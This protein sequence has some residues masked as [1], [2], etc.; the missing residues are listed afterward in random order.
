MSINF[1]VWLLSNLYF[2]CFTT[3]LISVFRWLFGIFGY[4][5]DM[6]NIHN[7]LNAFFFAQPLYPPKRHIP[8]FSGFL[9]CHIFKHF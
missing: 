2:I 3:F 6:V 8:F 7:T 1:S 4:E 5:P 9:C